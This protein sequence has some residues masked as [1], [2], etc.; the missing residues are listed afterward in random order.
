MDEIECPNCGDM[1]TPKRWNQR[2]CTAPCQK[3][4]GNRKLSEGAAMT[5][6]VKAWHE[7]RHADPGS[8]DARLCSRARRELTDLASLLVA[9]DREAGRSSAKYYADLVKD[10]GMVIDRL[11]K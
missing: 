9:R 1:F 6:L 8:E 2:F 7:T 10:G 3:A 5:T 11:R 4:N